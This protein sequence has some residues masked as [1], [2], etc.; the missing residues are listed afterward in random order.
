[1][2]KKEPSKDSEKAK[3]EPSSENDFELEDL[4]QRTQQLRV[5]DSRNG[6][7]SPDRERT[8]TSPFDYPMGP[9]WE[10]WVTVRVKPRSQCL[11]IVGNIYM[12]HRVVKFNNLV[13]NCD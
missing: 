1:M 12:S 11:T 7:F 4:A 5:G 9:N 2:D 3:S 13:K 10:I 6:E 8:A